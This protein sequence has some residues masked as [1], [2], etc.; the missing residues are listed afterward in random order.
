MCFR[1]TSSNPVRNLLEVREGL[2]MEKPESG[3]G[4]HLLVLMRT[5]PCHPHLQTQD[6]TWDPPSLSKTL[7][8][9]YKHQPLDI[10]ETNLF[11]KINPESIISMG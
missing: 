4:D 10:L 9:G 6:L 5:K 11:D 3:G 7:R 1:K 2:E 8:N